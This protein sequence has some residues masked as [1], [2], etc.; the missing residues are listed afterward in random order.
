MEY[1]PRVSYDLGINLYL[2]RDDLTG[3]GMGGNK[4]RKLE[5]F[6]YDAQQQGA[7]MLLTVGGAQTNHGRLTAAVAAKYGLKCVIVAIDEYP[8]EVSANILLDRMMGAEVILKEDDH[9]RPQSVQSQELAAV[10]KERYE[11][12]GE[13]VYFIPMGGSNELGIL[14][15]YDCAQELTIQAAEMGISDSRIITA[16]GSMGTYMGLFCGLKDI[17]SPLSLTGALIMPYE[18]SVRAFAKNYFDKVKE[19]YG[20]EFDA[21]KSDFHIDEDYVY[22]EYNNAVPEVREA[23]YQMARKESIILDPCYTGKAFNAICQMVRDRKIEQGETIIFLHTGGQP[24]I[25]TPHHRI[26]FERELI[27]GVKIL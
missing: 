21:E 6:L 25:N 8:D 24:G 3:Y 26:E 14:G 20:F 12:Q 16:V 18:E 7:T 5:Y 2:K 13:K 11:S 4:L 23:I 15:Y 1:L 10:I 17:E 22:G 27:D 9:I 19:H